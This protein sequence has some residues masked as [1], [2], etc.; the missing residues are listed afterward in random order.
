MLTSIT[1][2]VYNSSDKNS[3]V[4]AIALDIS[5]ALESGLNAGLLDE[6]LA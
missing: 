2:F 3:D 5:M 6:Y 4:P 1:E